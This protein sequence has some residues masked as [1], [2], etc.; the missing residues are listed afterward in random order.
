M[1]AVL[2]DVNLERGLRATM[3]R[4]A[5]TGRVPVIDMRADDAGARM[6]GG[7]DARALWGA[8]GQCCLRLLHYPP[9]DAVADDDAT[10]WRAGPHTDWC[11]VTLLYQRRA[12][13]ASSAAN[14]RRRGPG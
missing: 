12:T 1:A 8:G 3:T 5:S 14:Q 9:A 4:D 13:R 11:C 6:W 2:D 10:T 7:D